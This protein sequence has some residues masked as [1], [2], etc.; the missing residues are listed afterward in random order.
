VK[1]RVGICD[2]CGNQAGVNKHGIVVTHRG[3]FDNG[4]QG[5]PGSGK[6]ER[7]AS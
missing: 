5:C 6:P 4:R 2:T 1:R 3:N 7:K